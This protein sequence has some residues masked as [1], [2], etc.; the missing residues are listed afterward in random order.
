MHMASSTAGHDVLTV[1]LPKTVG[2]LRNP[3]AHTPESLRPAREFRQVSNY[4]PTLFHNTARM[5]SL[6]RDLEAYMQRLIRSGQTGPMN[7]ITYT[8][9]M[10]HESPPASWWTDSTFNKHLPNNT[11]R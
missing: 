5:R 7:S 8:A 11:M 1:Q 3:A 4:G 9:V 2:D 10:G 6:W